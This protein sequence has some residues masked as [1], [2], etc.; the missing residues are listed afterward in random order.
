MGSNAL[1]DTLPR[2]KPKPQ[3]PEPEFR[4]RRKA[5]NA[6]NA[7]KQPNP[8]LLGVTEVGNGFFLK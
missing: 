7:L 4:Q 5:R 3:P 8:H 6:V 1:D 2:E